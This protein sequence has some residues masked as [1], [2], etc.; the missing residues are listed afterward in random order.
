MAPSKTKL[1][2]PKEVSLESPPKDEL[3]MVELPN[4]ENKFFDV[5]DDVGASTIHDLL[6][7]VWH[8]AHFWMSYGRCTMPGSPMG[9]SEGLSRRWTG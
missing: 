3:P 9:R 7:E 5:D 4:D 1:V 6:T 8:M 2:K